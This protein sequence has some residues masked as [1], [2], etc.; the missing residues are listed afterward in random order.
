[1]LQYLGR[2]YVPYINR[3][4]G[5]SGTLWEGR[6]KASLIQEEDY[7]LACYRYIELNPVRAGMVDRPGHIAGPATIAAPWDSQTPHLGNDRFKEQVEA[8]VERTIGQAR[9]GRP[10]KTASNIL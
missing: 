3:R 7:L 9:R 8:M 10:K 1:L 5:R 6:Y 4:C 2:Y